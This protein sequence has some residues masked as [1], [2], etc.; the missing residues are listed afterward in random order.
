MKRLNMIMMLVV[1]VVIDQSLNASGKRKAN[2]MT[3]PLESS[4]SDRSAF[5]SVSSSILSCLDGND[6]SLLRAKAD[7]LV[8]RHVGTSSFSTNYNDRRIRGALNACK[9]RSKS[10]KDKA[11]RMTDAVE[12]ENNYRGSIRLMAKALEIQDKHGSDRSGRIDFSQA[13]AVCFSN[14]ADPQKRLGVFDMSENKDFPEAGT[15]DSDWFS[16]P[17]EYGKKRQK[18]IQGSSQ[19]NSVGREKGDDEI[20]RNILCTLDDANKDKCLK[21]SEKCETDSKFKSDYSILCANWTSCAKKIASSIS[22]NIRNCSNNRINGSAQKGIERL[23]ALTTL[24]GDAIT[25]SVSG[26]IAKQGKSSKERITLNE[27][28]IEKFKSHCA[29]K[30]CLSSDR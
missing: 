16:L 15:A 7:V 26:E 25:I 12:K 8:Q 4:V 9:M 14:V 29:D 13:D 17:V 19:D 23:N 5:P 3:C 18:V 24:N 10:L 28:Q 20:A 11:E 6:V 22:G 1:A 2:Q 30:T 27:V 21:V